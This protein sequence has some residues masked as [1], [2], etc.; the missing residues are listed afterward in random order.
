MRA[1]TVIAVIGFAIVFWVGPAAANP[2]P[3][4]IEISVTREG[5]SPKR[6]SVKK[7][8]P[9]TLVFTRRTDQTCAKDVVIYVDDVNK[10]TLKL[11]LNQPA[12]VTTTFWSTGERGFACSMKMHG[13]A[14]LV[15]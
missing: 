8:E 14:I 10:I 7:G 6:L 1:R 4:K 9:V 3:R 13:G 2:T 11:P 5:F 15:K 12:Q